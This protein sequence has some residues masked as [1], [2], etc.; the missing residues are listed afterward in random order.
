MKFIHTAPLHLLPII[1]ENKIQ[2]VYANHLSNEKYLNYFIDK[3]N[4][5]IILNSEGVDDF[6][7]L[8]TLCN[9][10]KANCII[11][12]NYPS[13]DTMETIDASMK[14]GKVFKGMGFKIMYAPQCM[15]GDLDDLI[16]G[17]HHAISADWIDYVMI[18]AQTA[19]LAYNINDNDKLK[20]NTRIKLMCELESK[21]ILRKLIDRDK[22]IHLHGL[23]YG[24]NEIISM[25]QFK[26]YI[27][28]WD[29]SIAIQLGI[30]NK[31]INNE[32]I[33]DKYDINISTENTESIEQASD[34]IE[35]ID[36]LIEEYYIMKEGANI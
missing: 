14:L 2:M 36:N 33:N 7:N 28:S 26:K 23:N 18:S 3:N 35:Y 6:G 22:K 31:S 17:F 9:K 20:H 21:G 29:S 25:K 27:N 10:L 5:E 12:P 11:L 24:Y 32:Y 34:N 1:D 4:Y 16:Y 13:Y 8:I 19:E 15:V 30:E